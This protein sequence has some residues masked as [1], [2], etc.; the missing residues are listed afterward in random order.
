MP[1]DLRHLHLPGVCL[2]IPTK[3]EDERGYFAEI[4][5][6]TTLSGLGIAD[7]FVQDNHSFSTKSVL[8]GLHFQRTPHVQAKLVRAVM[9]E[10][11]DVAVDL[12]ND[13]P[14]FGKWV[15]VNLS[16]SN[17]HMLYI[18]TGFAHGFCV[19]SET[20][21]VTYKTTSEYSSAHDAG[22]RWNDPAIGVAWPI[23]NP[24]LSEK[25]QALPFFEDMA[26]SLDFSYKEEG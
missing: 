26:D 17:S 16:G 15:G 25:D 2:V 6:K 7:E 18:P 1:F 8:R 19:L 10:I 5:R 20:A 11:Y 23:A 3:Y 22:I 4:Y 12:R 13:S 24:I 21:H 9:G 14:T